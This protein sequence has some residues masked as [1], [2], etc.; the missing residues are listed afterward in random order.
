MEVNFKFDI[1][2]QVW[3]MENNRPARFEVKNVKVEIESLVKDHKVTYLLM[4]QGV[5]REVDEKMVFK[6]KEELVE[7]L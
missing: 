2:E 3:I 5:Q 7:S 1:G 4:N 6:T